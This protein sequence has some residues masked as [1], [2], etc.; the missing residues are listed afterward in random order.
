MD[1]WFA[2]SVMAMGT[3]PAIYLIGMLPSLTTLQTASW[4]VE[5]SGRLDKE[6]ITQSV[7]RTFFRRIGEG[8]YEVPE[9]ETIWKLLA[10]ITLNK[11]RTVGTYHRAA[12]R[13]IRK[14]TPAEL[15]TLGNLLS[16]NEEALHVLHMTIQDIVGKLPEKQQK[17]IQLRLEGHE[18]AAIAESTKR[19]KRTVERVLQGFRGD[20]QRAIEGPAE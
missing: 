19:S 8:Q 11:I 5:L 2:P 15:S 16:T 3:R 18:V 14:S 9:G 10:V 13:D 17:I 12:K 1:R 7:F 6:D 20:L 4:P